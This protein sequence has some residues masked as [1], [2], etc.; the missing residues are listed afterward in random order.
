MRIKRWRPVLRAAGLH[1]APAPRLRLPVR[2]LDLA[3]REI[4]LDQLVVLACAVHEY[5]VAL[6]LP[7]TRSIGLVLASYSRSG[8]AGLERTACD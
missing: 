6:P 7:L 8:Y 5:A 3:R 4:P 1:I 2:Q